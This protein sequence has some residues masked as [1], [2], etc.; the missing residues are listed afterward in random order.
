MPLQLLQKPWPVLPCSGIIFT[1]IYLRKTTCMIMMSMTL[2]TKT[3]IVMTPLLG[4][5]PLAELVLPYSANE[6][7]LRIPCTLG[8]D[9]LNE[10]VC[11]PIAFKVNYKIHAPGKEPSHLNVK[12]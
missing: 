5:M 9:K 2:S 4:F 1:P 6:L 3:V 10:R 8:G 7:N 12:F 11:Y